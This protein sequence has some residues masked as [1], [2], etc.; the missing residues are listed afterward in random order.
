MC[1][2][3]QGTYSNICCVKIL[4]S[5]CPSTSVNS[6]VSYHCSCSGESGNYFQQGIYYRASRSNI[7]KLTHGEVTGIKPDYV[8]KLQCW[9]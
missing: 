4:K 6:I 8:G 7:E 2:L 3:L 1:F 9:F 5:L